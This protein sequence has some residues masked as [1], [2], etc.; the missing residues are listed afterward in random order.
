M[1]IACNR[2]VAELT[3]GTRSY[4][5]RRAASGALDRFPILQPLGDQ[6]HALA[7]RPV[8]PGCSCPLARR[9]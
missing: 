4:L 2:S 8:H 7:D 9:K 5:L 6:L 1:L 3:F